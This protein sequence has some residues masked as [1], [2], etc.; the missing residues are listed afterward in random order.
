MHLAQHVN[1]LTVSVAPSIGARWL[2][3]R[4][5][6]LR[7]AH[8][9]F[10]IRIDAK[11]SL[12]NFNN[13]GVDLAIRYGLGDYRPHISE[14]MLAADAFPVC[15]PALL[16]GGAS[17]KCPNDLAG[18]T[19]LHSSWTDASNSV[20]AWRMWLRAAGA[21]DVNPEPGPR[22]GNDNMLVEAA[23]AGQGV[24]LVNHAVV[25]RELDNGQLVR[26]FLP[27]VFEETAF[28]YFLVYPER[29]R[30]TPKVIAF[31]DWIFAEIANDASQS[32][33]DFQTQS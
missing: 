10:D 7:T 31:R 2:V 24:A 14:C 8:P 20:P 30:S 22:F 27:A 33:S 16:S 32:L 15:S 1:Y 25:A 29:H 18:F 11:D 19:L 3:P 9:E 13:D 21:D 26:P 23:L 12:A 5:E 17:L 6:R 28:C 4:L